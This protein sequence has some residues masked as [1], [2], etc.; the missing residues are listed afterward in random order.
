MTFIEETA[1]IASPLPNKPYEFMTGAEYL[2]SLNDGREIWFDGERVENVTEH[3]AFRNAARSMARLYDAM[4]DPGLTDDLTVVDK[5]GIR[6]HRFFAPAY[7]SEDLKQARTAID[8]WQRI[9]YGWM[10]RSPDYKAAFMAQL[11]EGY[12]F[13]APYGENALS[14]YKRYASKGLFL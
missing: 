5:F 8:I 9:N 14:W 4:H 12:D 10:G 7:S 1:A 6:T 11:A 13:Y 3:P 2:A